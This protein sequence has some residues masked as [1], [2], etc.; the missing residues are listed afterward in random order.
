MREFF[1]GWYM[2]VQDGT[3]TFAVIPAM[4]QTGSQRS[5]SIQIITGNHTWVVPFQEER[6]QKGNAF[7]RIGENYFSG[8][9]IMLKLNH[10]EVQIEGKLRF[11][12]LHTLKYDIMGPFTFVPLMECRH[13][14]FSMRHFVNGSLVLNG[15]KYEFN[16]AVG[17]WEGD[18][19]RSFPKEYLWTQCSFPKGSVMLSVAEI[20]VL[21][22]CFTGIIGVVFWEGK[23]FRFATYLGAKIITL[24]QGVVRI[25]QGNMEL[26][27]RLLEQTG[28]PLKA[29]ANGNMIRIIHESAACRA[30]YR[31]QIRGGIIFEFETPKASF[32]YEYSK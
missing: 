14:V 16:D 32:E 10:S 21:W 11:G 28:K 2:K 15:K 3:E 8:K 7:I 12:P 9:G 23:E 6:F 25:A 20:P 17:Y 31:F 13:S 24:K 1:E 4:H 18:R 29:P 19:G 30:Y 27:V 5:C 26:E 22:T